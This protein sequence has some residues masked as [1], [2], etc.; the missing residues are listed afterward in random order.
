MDSIKTSHSEQIQDLLKQIN[1][2]IRHIMLKE[3][4][5]YP[6]T[7]HQFHILKLIKKNPQINLTSLC[8]DLS[9]TKG[10]LS[11]TINKLVEEGY[12]LRKENASDRRNI[13]ILLTEKG[14][15]ILAETKDK[16]RE[17]FNLLTSALSDEDL[18]DITKSLAKL[19]ASIEKAVR[20]N[21]VVE[22][23]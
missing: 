11:L 3:F 8:G 12:V 15:K 23:E 14:E 6:L 10:S 21:Y 5:K 16:S 1:M 7:F 20:K 4:H 17:I 13:D 9:L 18:K 22:K 19:S 2:D